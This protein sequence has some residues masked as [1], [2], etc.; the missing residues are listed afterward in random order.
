MA[1][2][3]IPHTTPLF[4]SDDLIHQHT[5][6]QAL[7]DG[8]LV[9]VSSAAREYGILFPVALTRAVD[10]GC[11]TWTH[12]DIYQEEHGRLLDVVAML[13]MRLRVAKVRGGDVD[14]LSFAV[15]R[16]P[17]TGR[18]RMPRQV[19]LSVVCGPGDDSEPVL[20]VMLPEE[21]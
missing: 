2:D 21:D 5:R 4:T 13:A 7:A 15:L 8:D 17:N 1:T 19:N 20:T 3:L 16:I 6:A 18:G 14:R 11:V 12:D 9:D 10:V